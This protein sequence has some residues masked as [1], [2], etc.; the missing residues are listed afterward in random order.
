MSAA[1][2][3][4]AKERRAAELQ[5]ETLAL[6]LSS[7][8]QLGADELLALKLACEHDYLFF[9]RLFFK[10]IHGI[11]FDLAPY[12]FIIRDVIH[13]FIRL[14]IPRLIVNIPPRYSKTYMFII[15]LVAWALAQYRNSMFLHV[16]YAHDL[17]LRNSREARDIIQTPLYQMLWPG[18]LRADEHAKS[19]WVTEHGGGMNASAIG[20]QVTGFGAGRLIDPGPGGVL[21]FNGALLIDD[22]NKPIDNRSTVRVENA[23]EAYHGT[24]KSRIA[25]H[26]TPILCTQQRTGPTDLSGH[27]LEGGTKEKWT[28]LRIPIE[29]EETAYCDKKWTHAK[30][31]KHYLPAGPLWPFK[32]DEEAI[33]TLKAAESVFKTQYQQLPEN[34]FG[35]IF[36]WDFFRMAEEWDPVN[37]TVRIG[38]EWLSVDYLYMYG[39]TAEEVKKQ[40]DFSCFELWLKLKAGPIVLVDMRHE[41]VIAP[42]LEELAVNFINRYKFTAGLNNMAVRGMK[43]ELKSSG[44]GLIQHLNKREDMPFDIEGIERNRDKVSRANGCLPSIAQGDVFLL[45]NAPWISIIKKEIEDFSVDDTHDHDDTIDPMMDAIEDLLI[46]DEGLNY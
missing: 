45:R 23:I 16:S 19:A 29:V 33:E 40:N 28:H 13:A 12:H 7:P 10:V 26:R 41:K 44:R 20:G 9:C 43:V 21:K 35:K 6:A 36:K 22:P 42:D 3:L 25:T 18:A 27:F 8:S 4:Y 37:C 11:K 2:D 15:G 38:E 30:P 32:H 34:E 31:Y 5:R 39:D 46:F 1:E 14:E 17:A 24:L